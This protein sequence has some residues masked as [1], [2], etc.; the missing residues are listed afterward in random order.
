MAN[1]FWL[2][3]RQAVRHAIE[4]GGA[5][6]LYLPPYSQT[7]TS[8]SRSSPSSASRLRTKDPLRVQSYALV[9]S[10]VA[11]ERI[12]FVSLHHQSVHFT[13]FVLS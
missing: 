2:D 1:E 11:D 12:A 6:L 10:L 3:D 8:S 9:P 7:S 5:A 4:V 13:Y